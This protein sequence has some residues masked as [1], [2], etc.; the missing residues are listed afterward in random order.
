MKY[1][2]N[3]SITIFRP[4]QTKVFMIQKPVQ[5][6]GICILLA[7]LTACGGGGGDPI[8]M[9]DRPSGLTASIGNGQII[10]QW[11]PVPGATSYNIYAST[12]AG[13]QGK[14]LG[15]SSITR[16]LD[17]TVQNGTAYRYTVAAIVAGSTLLS[18]QSDPFKPSQPAVQRIPNTGQT[19]SYAAGDNGTYSNINSMSYADNGNGTVTDKV[20][21][22]MWQKQDNGTPLNWFSAMP[23]CAGLDL[24]GSKDWR[25][26]SAGELQGIVN[27]GRFFPAITAE[28]FPSTQSASYFSSTSYTPSPSFAWLIPF[29]DAT[30]LWGYKS[31][32][33]YARCVRQGTQSASSFND[34]GDGTVTDNVTGNMWQQY[35]DTRARDWGS[36][37]RYCAGLFL[38]GQAG[39]RLPTIK[40]LNSISDLSTSN[41]SINTIYFPRTSSTFFWSSTSYAFAPTNAWGVAVYDASVY[42]NDKNSAGSTRCTRQG[43]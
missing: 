15:S 2:W 13:V 5:Q 43:Q 14:L 33:G 10:L 1:L 39:W 18:S 21:G 22:L 38:G 41:P 42:A 12:T 9:P 11:Q 4:P 37:V 6:A 28:V 26:P 17:S 24:G 20:T 27:F 35:D 19:I 29:Y 8:A 40:E 25:L 16:F 30:S 34:N 36:A 23:Y 32:P 7:A 3:A 31:A